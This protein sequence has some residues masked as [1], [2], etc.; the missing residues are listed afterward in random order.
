MNESMNEC[1]WENA[2]ICTLLHAIYFTWKC[3]PVSHCEFVLEI[4]SFHNI[5]WRPF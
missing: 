1:F 3:S 4:G 5:S 2:C